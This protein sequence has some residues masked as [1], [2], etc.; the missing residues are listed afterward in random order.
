[1]CATAQIPCVLSE[2]KGE[3]G[4]GTGVDHRNVATGRVGN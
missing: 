1:M 4:K 3:A 2:I